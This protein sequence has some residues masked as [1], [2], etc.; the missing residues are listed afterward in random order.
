MLERRMLIKLA[1]LHGAAVLVHL[2]LSLFI[3][4][5]DAFETLREREAV[6]LLVPGWDLTPT[7]SSSGDPILSPC[8]K[9]SGVSLNLWFVTEIFNSVTTFA[10]LIYLCLCL[11]PLYRRE[12]AS[13]RVYPAPA[14]QRGIFLGR[15]LEY[16]ITAPAMIVLISVQIG[17]RDLFTYIHGVILTALVMIVGG[18]V[19]QYFYPYLKNTTRSGN[20]IAP[21]E[22][23]RLL[24]IQRGTSV[25]NT[26]GSLSPQQHIVMQP[27]RAQ[28]NGVY[29]P[30]YVN[31]K[32]KSCSSFFVGTDVD[33]WHLFSWFLLLQSWVPIFGITRS[34]LQ[35]ARSDP[36][37]EAPI[38]VI[39]AVVICEFFFFSAFGIV[40]T[41]KVKRE[42]GKAPK[43]REKLY[44]RVEM[45]YIVLSVTSKSLLIALTSLSLSQMPDFQ[46]GTE[47]L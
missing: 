41:F 27:T 13:D 8:V 20:S 31:P 2:F 45:A 1:I 11:W 18:F 37:N 5:G 3:A 17:A 4:F 22:T 16:S 40:E 21:H 23:H 24:T 30:A 12:E 29:P 6:G 44:R 36:S 42:R 46:T 32:S 26:H 9:Q 43:E 35:S 14:V 34:S 19:P 15:W 47:C 7:N 25:P 33:R 38:A 28:S 39:I 10:H